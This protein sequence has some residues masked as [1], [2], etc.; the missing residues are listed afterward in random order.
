MGA[1]VAFNGFALGGGDEDGSA[2]L[3]DQSGGLAPEAAAVALGATSDA[4]ASRPAGGTVLAANEP[5]SAAAASRG[6]DGGRAPG[7]PVTAAADEPDSPVAP[8]TVAGGGVQGV[9]SAVDDSLSD[10][11]AGGGIS[12]AA[13]PVAGQVD[14]AV[15]GALDGVDGLLDDT[16][17]GGQGDR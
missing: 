11:G 15:E 14:E 13:G 6:A 12:D 9:V 8:P 5:R 4:V 10:A 2:S 17:L 3:A 1:L 7:A 16:G